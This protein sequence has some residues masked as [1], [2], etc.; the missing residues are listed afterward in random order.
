MAIPSITPLP[1]APL[2]NDPDFSTK[3]G[4]WA[5]ALAD[6]YTPQLN[7]FSAA[8]VAEAQGVIAGVAS[9]NGETGILT[10]F[11]KKSAETMTNLTVAGW[12][13]EGVFTITDGASVDIDP[14]NGTEQFWTLGANRTPTATNM[15]DGQSV[16][17]YI[18]D[19]TAYAVTWSTIG[20]VWAGGVAP[21]LPA[22]GYAV[23]TLSK[24]G[25][26]VRGFSAQ[27][28]AS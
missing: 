11:A 23:I 5:L 10:G 20:V 4:A 21:V 9:V 15:V 12:V 14:A 7:A 26:V 6:T 18:A 22:A 8:L 25:G 1:A 13:K 27:E 19:G 28:T 17:L 2:R 24:A 3:A 16:T